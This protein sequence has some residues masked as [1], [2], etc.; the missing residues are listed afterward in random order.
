M[1]TPRFL[2]SKFN[3][4]YFVIENFTIIALVINGDNIDGSFLD[5]DFIV[6]VQILFWLRWG[7]MQI[8][9][10]NLLLS[11]GGDL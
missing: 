10:K 7:K 8:C 11:S 9:G 5:K 4:L 3:N 2:G 1:G 6:I